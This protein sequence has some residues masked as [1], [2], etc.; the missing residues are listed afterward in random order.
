VGL[1]TMLLRHGIGKRADSGS[2]HRCLLA[3]QLETARPGGAD[4]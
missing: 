2:E 1:R 3:P 4:H